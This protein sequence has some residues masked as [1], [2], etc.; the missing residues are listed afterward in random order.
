MIKPVFVD[1]FILWKSQRAIAYR[2]A[3]H[4]GY[5]IEYEDETQGLDSSLC[6]APVA[7]P[8]SPS[9]HRR[10]ARDKS[11]NC[12]GALASLRLE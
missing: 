4:E 10:R 9:R 8:Y 3:K 1:Q 5:A 2:Q 11:L 7:F 6:V 12:K